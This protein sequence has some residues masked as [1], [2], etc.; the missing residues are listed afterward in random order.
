MFRGPAKPSLFRLSIPSSIKNANFG[1]NEYLRLFC[2]SATIPEISL[3]TI[4]A[5][6]QERMGVVRQQ[7]VG[8]MYAK[9]LT[10]TVIERTDFIAYN[11]IKEWF[12]LISPDANDFLDLSHRMAYYDTYTCDIKLKKLESALEQNIRNTR[13]GYESPLTVIFKNA[14]PTSIGSI[15]FDNE[16]QNSLVTYD[17]SFS[18]TTYTTR[19][20]DIDNDD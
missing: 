17:V 13:D 2:K 5:N 10:I 20:D 1:A 7:P 11:N 15:S 8:I 19:K 9:P 4:G 6:G 3:E 16:A 18:Y 14:F 12:D